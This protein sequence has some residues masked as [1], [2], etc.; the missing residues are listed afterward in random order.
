MQCS[1]PDAPMMCQPGSHGKRATIRV[2]P[3][4]Q[5]MWTRD[6]RRQAARHAASGLLYGYRNSRRAIKVI[7][8]TSPPSRSRRA[9]SK[10]GMREWKSR[11]TER[12]YTVS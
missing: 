12:G 3:K 1:S 10:E 2:Y 11:C 9:A 4:G 7:V 5:M 6:N 8:V